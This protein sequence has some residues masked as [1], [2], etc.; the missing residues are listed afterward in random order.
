MINIYI[1]I[2]IISIGI[3]L[4]KIDTKEKNIGKIYLKKF[5]SELFEFIW[6]PIGYY[7][8]KILNLKIESDF[9]DN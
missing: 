6:V 8:I 7:L 5:I 9:W 2:F 4:A 1:S 3:V